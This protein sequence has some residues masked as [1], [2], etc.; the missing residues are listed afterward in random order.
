MIGIS[1]PFVEEA[2]HQL[3][4]ADADVVVLVAFRVEDEEAYLFLVVM[5]S[6]AERWRTTT[7]VDNDKFPRM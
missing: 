6:M 3:L 7:A 5:H 2:Q 4:V 1:M